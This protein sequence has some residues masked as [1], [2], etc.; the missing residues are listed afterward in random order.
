MVVDESSSSPSSQPPRSPSSRNRGLP[1]RV[2][3]APAR[4]RSRVRRSASAV[5]A[6][7]CEWSPGVHGAPR[8]SMLG[9]ARPGGGGSR[10]T[11]RPSDTDPAVRRGSSRPAAAAARTCGAG[12][13]GT[14][15]HSPRSLRPPAAHPSR[16]SS[17][18]KTRA[19]APCCP[20]PR[21]TPSTGDTP[22]ACVKSAKTGE[23]TLSE[24]GTTRAYPMRR[25][26]CR[27][28]SGASTWRRLA[29]VLAHRGPR[30]RSR[31]ASIP[32]LAR[33]K[34]LKSAVGRTRVLFDVN[35]G[36]RAAYLRG[37]I[38]HIRAVCRRGWR[39]PPRRPIVAHRAPSRGS[40]W[41]ESNARGAGSV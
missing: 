6:A 10:R 18:P 7:V 2:G 19:A 11:P 3:D 4:L 29:L 22:A 13:R 12:A 35:S 36:R 9:G 8:A 28:Q 39:C 23:M 20:E 25:C 37:H 31:R 41:T 5:S 24:N 27:A 14:S 15:P 16:T 30:A 26:R 17:P 33:K 38:R 1:R 34:L 40:L 21:N 32:A